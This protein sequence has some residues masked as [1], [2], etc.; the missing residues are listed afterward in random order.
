MAKITGGLA[1]GKR[2]IPISLTFYT[3]VGMVKKAGFG[4]NSLLLEVWIF[5]F[6]FG[7]SLL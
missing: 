2:D 6:G 4:Y 5:N 3:A 7:L 1:F